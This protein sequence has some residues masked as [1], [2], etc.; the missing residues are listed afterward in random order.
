MPYPHKY[1]TLTPEEREKIKREL[2]RLT[3]LEKWKKRKPLQALYLS[4][5]KKTISS[6]AKY[7][8]KSHWTIRRWIYL[9][10]K[11]GLEEVIEWIN[12]PGFF[13]GKK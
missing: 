3:R 8:G 11:K 12:R 4:D 6:I 13:K 9:Y 10:R 7:L 2:E 1:I 5:Q